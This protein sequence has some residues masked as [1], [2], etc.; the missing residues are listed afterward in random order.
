MDVIQYVR[1]DPRAKAEVGILV[2]SNVDSKSKEN[3]DAPNTT[4]NDII[5]RS[6]NCLK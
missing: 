4:R 1:K 5:I 3:I 6:V 2:N